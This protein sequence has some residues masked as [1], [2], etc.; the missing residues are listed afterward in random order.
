MVVQASKGR[1]G[2]A[3]TACR[4]GLA[5]LLA[6]RVFKAL[7]D[8]RRVALLVRLAEARGPRTVSEIARGSTVDLSVVSRH[9]AVLRE[10]GVIECARRGKEVLCT[11]RTD[12][13]ARFLR[14]LA[15]ALEQCCP[16]E[17][18]HGGASVGIA[19]GERPG[20]CT[21]AGGRSPS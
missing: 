3:G 13:L 7:G 16:R 19:G 20:R 14:D 1:Q 8:P 18:A 15:N 10:A 2:R 9:L 17:A 4:G 6:P 5:E 21:P 12:T 11:V